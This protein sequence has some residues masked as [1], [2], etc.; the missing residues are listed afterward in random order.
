MGPPLVIKCLFYHNCK[1]IL[2]HRFSQET[3]HPRSFRRLFIVFV[4]RKTNYKRPVLFTY[5]KTLVP[6]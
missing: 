5:L 2:R 1:Q 4:C 3:L 6:L